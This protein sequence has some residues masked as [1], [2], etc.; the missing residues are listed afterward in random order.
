MNRD[1][2]K[3]ALGRLATDVSGGL[4]AAVRSERELAQVFQALKATGGR[5]VTDLA[6]STEALAQV[7]PVNAAAAT[8]E[9][10]TGAKLRAVEA[11][12]EV[13]G[14]TLGALTPQSWSLTVG[15]LLE[16]PY[17]GLRA[18]RGGRLEPLAMA[19]TGVLADG[20][21][22][23]TH[24][25]PRA[26]A[27]PDLNAVF[28]G[29]QRRLGVLT[30]ATLRAEPK[31]HVEE[32]VGYSFASPAAALEALR[33]SLADGLAIERAM[34]CRDGDAVHVSVWLFSADPA[35]AAREAASFGR[36]ARQHEGVSGSA[37]IAPPLS[38]EEREVSWPALAAALAHAGSLGLWRLSLQSVVAVG[39]VEG[40]RLTHGAPWQQGQALPST[41]DA[42]S[43]L[44]GP[45]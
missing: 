41:F 33:A 4:L 23:R 13:A 35:S 43:L 34:L 1:E 17:A 22:V 42:T 29:A 5:L 24:G 3:A 39:N 15:E 45:P 20:S 18:V 30:A 31:G 9:V 8:I 37:T 14:L 10:G 40:D 44:G 2:L 32:P 21:I 28:L 19:L 38:S 12:L 16:G 11:A 25:S 27:G 6:L 36:R 7:G 26:A